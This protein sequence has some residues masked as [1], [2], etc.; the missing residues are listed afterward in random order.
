LARA[1]S[2]L[3]RQHWL[4]LV[5]AIVAVAARAWRFG[6][7]P[8]GLNI[9]EASGAYDAFSL[10]ERGVDRS[11][12]PYPSIFTAFGSGMHPFAY[13]LSMP[14]LS[15]FGIHA[16]TIRIPALLLNLAALPAFAVLGQSA[17]G[18]RMAVLCI[19][20]L[21][22]APWSL[23]A[24]RWSHEL[25]VFPALFTIGVALLVSS[26]QRPWLLPLGL[27]T[28]ALCLYSYGPA[29]L[30]VPLFV[31]PALVLL[32]RR[33]VV[34]RR[35]LAAGI[36]VFLVSAT[37]IAAFLAVNQLH[38]RSIELPVLSI[39]RL[40]GVPRYQT[41]ASALVSEAAGSVTS[42]LASLLRLLWTQDD[43]LVWNSVSGYGVVYLW[44]LP[45]AALGALRTA[46]WALEARASVAPTVILIW[47]GAGVA[48]ATVMPPNLNRINVL[49]P[50][51]LFFAAAGLESLWRSRPL[52]WA[53]IGAY[54]VSF[55]GLLFAYFET[56]PAKVGPA[57]FAS[58]DE[59]I[60]EAS[61]ATAGRICV[62]DHVNYGLS[63]VYVLLAQRIDPL[64]YRQ[65]VRIENPGAEFQKVTSFDR[66][67]FGLDHCSAASVSAYVIEAAELPSLP[68]GAYR[69]T[70]FDRYVVAVPRSATT[71]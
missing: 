42:N 21:A 53:L 35:I 4:T 43:G 34:E 52:F 28:F 3:F 68:P 47:F 61:S 9:D 15:A 25:T 36:A 57:F 11:G 67:T 54:V 62:T 56:Y 48:L 22:I 30:V 38:L 50:P 14:W 66:Y 19:F 29:L 44:S 63:Y 20:L 27:L 39:P 70:G 60:D 1:C 37:P 58:I 51:L 49:Y 71:K 69:V 23:L 65:T 59:A 46:Q 24:S 7:V 33:R 2:D 12:L 31:V 8:P 40:S 6:Q 16:W 5:I 18:R 41:M 10:L 32:W 64:V 26:Q 45:L 17:R 55:T 13:Y